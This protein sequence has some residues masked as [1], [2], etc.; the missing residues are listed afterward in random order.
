LCAPAA[1]RV[2]STGKIK[3][4]SSF[5]FVENIETQPTRKLKAAKQ[6]SSNPTGLRKTSKNV[7]TNHFAA[8]NDRR[9]SGMKVVFH[10]KS[11]VRLFT[12]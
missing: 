9:G 10:S 3:I 4:N 1:S 2:T 5:L 11:K 6:V 8:W 7:L 12:A